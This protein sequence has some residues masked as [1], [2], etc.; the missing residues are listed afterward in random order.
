MALPGVGVTA[1]T[2][3]TGRAAAVRGAASSPCASAMPGLQRSSRLLTPL[4][5]PLR[6]PRA[7]IRSQPPEHPLSPAEQAIAFSIMFGCFLL[8]TGWILGNIE[9]YKSRPE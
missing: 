9:H 1:V 5:R 8:P 2:A 7:H 4:L 3:V 6:V